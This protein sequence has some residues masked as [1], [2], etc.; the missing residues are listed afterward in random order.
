[1]LPIVDQM[2]NGETPT[3]ARLG[4]EVADVADETGAEV[5][6]GAQVQEVGDGSPPRTPASPWAT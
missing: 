2:S 6:E 5:T 4:I 1:M 3:H